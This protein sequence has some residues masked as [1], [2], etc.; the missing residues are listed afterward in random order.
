MNS[1]HNKTRKLTV[2]T[3]EERKLMAGS[4][5][6]TADG[7]LFIQ[8]SYLNDTALIYYS[9]DDIG[10]QHSTVNL[11]TNEY[12]STIATFDA[13]A[14]ARVEFWGEEGADSFQ[15]ATHLES[16][17]IGGSGN[18][19]LRGG[20]ANDS[21]FGGTGNDHLN[22]G[23]GDDTLSGG[24][25]NDRLNG[26]LGNDLIFGNN[27]ID[28]YRRYRDTSTADND[29]LEG[30]WGNDTLYGGD[31]NDVLIGGMGRDQL[32]GGIGG[33]YLDGGM[34]KQDDGDRDT[35]AGGK[36]Y[37]HFVDYQHYGS[38]GWTSKDTIV[39]FRQRRPSTS[40][41]ALAEFLAK[42]NPWLDFSY[43][44]KTLIREYA[45]VYG[46]TGVSGVSSLLTKLR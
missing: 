18:D 44:T 16:L 24:S 19:Y 4:I 7:T 46:N 34:D 35:L 25:G 41:S 20:R 29:Y 2:E 22:G 14:V 26:S 10:V 9:G 28:P 32:D 30:G 36:G 43:D 17:A 27:S 31:W 42:Q 15:N 23:Q 21:L 1:K 40:S 11:S 37:D 33:D 5:E 6:L 3:V 45:M 39:D 12:T 13:D 8:G 38:N